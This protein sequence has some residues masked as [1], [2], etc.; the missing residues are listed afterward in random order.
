MSSDESFSDY[1]ATQH[2]AEG[3]ALLAAAQGSK[4]TTYEWE[5][6]EADRLIQAA[7]A[8]FSAAKAIAAVQG[9]VVAQPKDT[10]VAALPDEELL[11][12]PVGTRIRGIL[13]D[14]LE[15][16]A[17]EYYARSNHGA[18]ASAIM[19]GITKARDFV[20]PEAAWDG[21]RD[22]GEWDEPYTPTVEDRAELLRRI[23]E[24]KGVSDQTEA[25]RLAMAIAD[26]RQTEAKS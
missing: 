20:Y 23:K 10:D 9:V 11:N 22:A 14:L 25:E 7:R 8:H 3:K 12:S 16:H 6:P 13:H 19:G 17:E 1:T 2:I 21:F 26:E 24:R 4:N 15:K 18:T 5:N